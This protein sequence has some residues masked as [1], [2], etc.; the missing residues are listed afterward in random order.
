MW[1]LLYQLEIFLSQWLEKNKF[2]SKKKSHYNDKQTILASCY[3]RM[4]LNSNNSQL[5]LQKKINDKKLSPSGK[6]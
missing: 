2:W 4:N 5:I 3:L 1:Y 6:Y